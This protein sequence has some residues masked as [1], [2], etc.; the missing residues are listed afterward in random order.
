MRDVRHPAAA[1]GVQ[2][3]PASVT[4]GVKQAGLC[5]RPWLCCRSLGFLR[6]LRI[7]VLVCV[8]ALHTAIRASYRGSG[9]RTSPASRVP[10]RRRTVRRRGRTSDGSLSWRASLSGRVQHAPCISVFHSQ[11][12]QPKSP[13]RTIPLASCAG[14]TRGLCDIKGPAIFGMAPSPPRRME[15]RPPPPPP[16]NEPDPVQNV[17][18]VFPKWRGQMTAAP[19][20][21]LRLWR[22]HQGVSLSVQHRGPGGPYWGCARQFCACPCRANQ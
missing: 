20:A 8:R 21:F 15:Q 2:V 6:I 11:Q 19:G 13:P 3:A 14:G 9:S 22:I 12:G 7:W 1:L 10:C 5:R 18:G 4:G 16:T 17:M